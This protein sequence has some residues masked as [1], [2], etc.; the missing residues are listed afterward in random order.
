MAGSAFDVTARTESA[1]MSHPSGVFGECT[2]RVIEA[3]PPVLV[4]VRTHAPDATTTELLVEYEVRGTA[5]RV[6]YALAERPDV[7]TGGQVSAPNRPKEYRS[8]TL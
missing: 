2:Y 6:F 4:N 8:F 7:E 5:G 1:L 3:V